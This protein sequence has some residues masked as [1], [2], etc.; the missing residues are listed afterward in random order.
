VR[1]VS[2]FVLGGILS[3]WVLAPSAPAGAETPQQPEPAVEEIVPY[4]VSQ[5][6]VLRIAVWKEPEL[7]SDVFVRLDGIITVPLV[8]D[9]RAAGKTTEQIATEVRTRLRAFLEVPQVTVTVSQATSARFY[10][11]GEVTNSGSFPLTGRITVLQALALAG[12]FR[13]F[14]KKGQ[15]MIIRD[16]HGDRRA[17]KFDF[18]ELA[19]GNGLKQN[20]PLEAGDTL[21]VP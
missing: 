5:G 21:I 4:Y 6:D 2:R 7:T 20:I 15:V 16:R 12:G 9:V 10:V 14:A 1:S 17:I 19:V 11:I 8:G 13:E 18:T 3:I